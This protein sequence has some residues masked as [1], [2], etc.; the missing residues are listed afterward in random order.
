MPINVA[1]G[2]NNGA[3]A[4]ATTLDLASVV[5]AAG[6]RILIAMRYNSTTATASV[7][8][9]ANTYN[10]VGAYRTGSADRQTLFEAINV[11]AGTRTVT[12][13]FS[14]S[15]GNRY[16]VALKST[17]S[18]SSASQAVLMNDTGGAASWTTTADNISTG[19]MTP[20]SQPNAIVGIFQT[21]INTSPITNGTGLTSLGS[22]TNWD[23]VLNDTS[24]VNWKRT[25]STS[26]AAATAQLSA[27]TDGGFTWGIVIGESPGSPTID[28]QPT[29]QAGSVGGT[30]TYSI[31]ATTSG[32][33][34]SYQW[35]LN[36]SNVGTNSSSY[37]TATLSAADNGGI[38]T[39]V[40]TDSNGSTTSNGAY[41]FIRGIVTGKGRYFTGWLQ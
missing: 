13:T 6:D 1:L 14:A 39:C 29:N 34:L 20:T 21:D 40:V 7:S 24:L 41:L 16:G 9:G 5:M 23:S 15:V 37:T 36:G 33:A 31:S 28:T 12:I 2:I 19:N 25:T 38:V 18:N 17:G 35:K 30:A 22:L 32:G 10:Q 3:S 27:G 4:S 8:D 26:A 11:T